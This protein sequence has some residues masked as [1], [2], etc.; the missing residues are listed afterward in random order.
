MDG[1]HVN[2][3][4]FPFLEFPFLEFPS[5]E[6]TSLELPSLD[7]TGGWAPSPAAFAPPP[8]PNQGLRPWNPCP[9]IYQTKLRAC[10]TAS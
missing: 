2:S 6:L 9:P 10:F 3:A 4:A 8:S 7:P 1:Y 5:L